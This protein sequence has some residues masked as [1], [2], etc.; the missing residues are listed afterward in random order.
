M[1]ITKL[2]NRYNA[3]KKW[4]F[5]YS[6]TFQG[7]EWNSYYAFKRKTTEL[8]NDSKEIKKSFMW[9][10]D[11]DFLRVAP[12]ACHY[13]KSSKPMIIYFRNEVDM[14]QVIMMFA[15]SKPENT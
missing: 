9:K 1:K 5:T 4:G 3:C 7:F 12:W 6:V 13:D 2:N 14:N 8:F 11:I 15:L 10:D